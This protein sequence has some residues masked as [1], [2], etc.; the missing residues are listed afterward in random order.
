MGDLQ[1]ITTSNMEMQSLEFALVIFS[2]AL[3]QY[4]FSMLPFLHF[5]TVMYI[6]CHDM[7]EVCDLLFDSIG[8]YS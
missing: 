1:S 7:L 5:G 2:L 6:L 8:D 4:F 3:V